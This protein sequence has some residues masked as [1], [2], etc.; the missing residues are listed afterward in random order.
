[1][2]SLLLYHQVGVG[3]RFVGMH[4]DS[5]HVGT[6][7]VPTA[8]DYSRAKVMRTIRESLETTYQESSVKP[9]RNYR[10]PDRSGTH[11]QSNPSPAYSNQV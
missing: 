8:S 11:Q 1:M 5:W 10:E 3:G 9:G 4:H 2:T 7:S 6:L